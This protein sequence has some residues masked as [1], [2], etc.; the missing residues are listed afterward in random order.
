MTQST[1]LAYPEVFGQLCHVD[2]AVLVA[3]AQQ[4]LERPPL[5]RTP[6]RLGLP[7]G[8][9]LLHLFTSTIARQEVRDKGSRG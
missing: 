3:R 5:A 4:P 1:P 8:P 7:R 6:G 9:T 2:T